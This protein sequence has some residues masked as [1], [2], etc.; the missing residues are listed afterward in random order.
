MIIQI[1]IQIIIIAMIIAII[2]LLI[3]TINE[4]KSLKEKLKADYETAVGTIITQQKQLT[5]KDSQI[6]DLVDDNRKL[7][8]ELTVVKQRLLKCLEE[9]KH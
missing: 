5:L 8:D 2:F 9:K 7:K 1:I 4:D 6:S 3:E